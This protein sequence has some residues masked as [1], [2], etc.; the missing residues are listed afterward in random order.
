MAAVP[1]A[2]ME[3]APVIKKRAEG[4]DVD[5]SRKKAKS[6]PQQQEELDREQKKLAKDPKG[7]LLLQQAKLTESKIQEATK[8]EKSSIEVYRA[9]V[10]LIWLGQE[11][12]VHLAPR[13]A[14][15]YIAAGVKA[16]KKLNPHIELKNVS[17]GALKK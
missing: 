12:A 2:T 6:S 11:L 17:P 7:R 15:H 4:K 10:H 14:E 16:A 13:S 8:S 5:A 3:P 9:G 1:A